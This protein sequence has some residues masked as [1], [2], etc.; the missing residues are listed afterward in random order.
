MRMASFLLGMIG[1]VQVKKMYRKRE[2]ATKEEFFAEK[3]RGGLS[4]ADFAK[5]VYV[6]VHTFYI[7][8]QG[9]LKHEFGVF[10]QG[11]SG[12]Y[13]PDANFEYMYQ[14][15]PILVMDRLVNDVR[16][17][18]EISSMKF[19][20][21]TVLAL[22]FDLWMIE[23]HRA[24][25][26]LTLAFF[27]AYIKEK[28]GDFLDRQ[29]S[30]FKSFDLYRI[31]SF[32]EI[33]GELVPYQN[34]IGEFFDQLCEANKSRINMDR[35]DVPRTKEYAVVEEKKP[36]AVR[37]THTEDPH[38][39]AAEPVKIPAQSVD[40]ADIR[41]KLERETQ[42]ILQEKDERISKL[43]KDIREFKRQRDEA[44]EY[45]L[46]QYDRG[47]KDLF[48]LMNDIRYGKVIDYLFSLLQKEEIDDNLAGYLE[49]FFLLLEDMEIEPIC[50][51]EDEVSDENVTKNYNLDFD[52]KCY[53]PGNVKVKYVGW[54]YKDVPIEKPTIT[55]KEEK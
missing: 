6:A 33:A 43:E 44:R 41:R 1:K 53:E 18:K 42:I 38:A 49:N 50:D 9:K 23:R 40:E 25:K 55:L 35:C 7:K 10:L 31:D 8:K 34:Q 26:Q 24:G 16:S 51:Y 37:E 32:E 48:K 17:K 13:M 2:Q 28:Y 30:S 39:A 54:K 14:T 11:I 19:L 5:R 21:K 15:E 12:E 22:E 4:E 52:K 3:Y 47:V 36:E 29:Y 46:N 45:S 20:V 27:Y